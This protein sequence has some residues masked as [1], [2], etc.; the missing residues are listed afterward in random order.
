MRRLLFLNGIKAFEAAARSGS[1]AAAGLELNVSAAAI[2]R[3]VH[4][5]EDRLGVAL[6]ERKANRLALTSAGR[7]YQSGLTP[8][9][10]ALASL[11]AQV[12]APARVVAGRSCRVGSRARRGV[13]TRGYSCRWRRAPCGSPQRRS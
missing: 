5:L 1:F 11:T 12:T 6:F 2:S 7:A 10:D 13:A 9:F 8:I 4:L 3:M